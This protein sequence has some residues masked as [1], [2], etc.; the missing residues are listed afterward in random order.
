MSDC[1]SRFQTALI[2]NSNEIH[3]NGKQGWKLVA[4]SIEF[5]FASRPKVLHSSSSSVIFIAF[6]L[7]SSNFRQVL[8]KFKTLS[9]FARWSLEI[10][11]FEFK[12][13]SLKKDPSS[14][15]QQFKFAALPLFE[16]V[17]YSER[18]DSA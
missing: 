1:T 13:E 4:F 17:L 5:V 8:D 15:V 12:F 14:A 7:S 6:M 3:K 2:Q 18:S 16:S 10:L 11:F 9:T